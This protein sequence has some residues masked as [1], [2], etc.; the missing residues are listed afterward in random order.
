MN[1][2]KKFD[3]L[4][5]KIEEL[6][7]KLIVSDNPKPT[8]N[9]NGFLKFTETE[10]SKMPKTF[11]KTFRLNGA[12][13]HVRKRTDGRYNCSYEIRYAKKPYDMHPISVS[14]TTLEAVKQRFIDKTK[15]LST[16]PDNY[17]AMA[18]PTNFHEFAM[19]WFENFH[20]RKVVEGTY[21]RSVGRY[22]LYIKPLFEKRKVS[23]IYAPEIQRLLDSLADRH[24]LEED[25]HSLLNQIFACAVKH[26]LVKINPVG[27]CFHQNGERTHGTAFSKTE[28]EKL[29]NAYDGKVRT[30]LAI[31]LYTG[32]R[33][34]E[35]ATATLDGSFIKAI[36]SKR[37]NGKIECKR[38]P[39]TD[40]LRP[41][42]Q[43]VT[44]LPKVTTCLLNKRIKAIFPEHT[45]YNA[46]TTFQ[47][48]CTECGINETV[49]GLW[50]GNS[51]GKLKK[52]YTDL[53]DEF[54]LKEAK[55]FKY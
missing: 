29:L 5:Q 40:M 2:Q 51:I 20:K 18:I 37:K 1:T 4:L 21:R 55:K 33:P 34:N 32:L 43:G 9:E 39:I 10:I 41:Y 7:T 16:I 17:A 42:L 50:M 15:T 23:E 14:A 12:T 6:E 38:I 26:G 44:E 19:F 47:S 49:I 45:L 48:R 3:T 30:A 8:T 31:M 22:N 54:M 53:S 36:N 25:T 46:R 13:V 24:R 28:E 27:M 52:A 11:R 35:Y